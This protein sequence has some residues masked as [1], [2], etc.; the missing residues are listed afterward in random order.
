MTAKQ[1]GWFECLECRH[2]WYV[3]LEPGETADWKDCPECDEQGRMVKYVTAHVNR[4]I[5]MDAKTGE[6]LDE[7]I[8]AA[9]RRLEREGSQ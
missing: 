5:S 7:I 1:Q 3:V 9:A 2:R 4:D 6:A 8:K